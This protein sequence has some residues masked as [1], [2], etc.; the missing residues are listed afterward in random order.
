MIINIT[1]AG[2]L[3]STIMYGIVHGVWL[4]GKKLGVITYKEVRAERNRIIHRHVKT[5]HETRLKQCPDDECTSLRSWEPPLALP[6]R[7]E[8]EPEL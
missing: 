1:P 4:V 6:V 8:I 3:E 5:G 2:V 7:P